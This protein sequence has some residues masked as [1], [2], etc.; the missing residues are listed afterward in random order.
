[1]IPI[2]C[3]VVKNGKLTLTD[4][5]RY[6]AY[7]ATLQGEVDVVVR[8]PR[9]QR[10]SPQNK[11]LWGVVYALISEHTGFTL[12]EVHDAMRLMF[13]RDEDKS[14]PTLKST[15][16]LSV[17]E[18]SRYWEQIRLFAAEKLD[19]QIPDPNEVIA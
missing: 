3:G 16:S 19:L 13:L 11:F 4:E 15:T 12:D 8:R 6:S 17:V 5:R 1:M 7:L 18:M 2:F 10:T 14:I 9:K